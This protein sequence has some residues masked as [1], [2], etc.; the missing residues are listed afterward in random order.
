MSFADPRTSIAAAGL[1]A[2]AVGLLG[3][4]GGLLWLIGGIWTA[5]AMAAAPVGAAWGLACLAAGLRWGSLD[6]GDLQVATRL[7][8][9]TVAAGGLATRAGMVLA[10]AGALIGEARVDGLRARTFG[11]RAAAMIALTALV[12]LF[13][14]EGP[15]RSGVVAFGWW[16]LAGVVVTALVVALTP[17][18][19]RLPAL[20][21][22]GLVGAGMVLAGA[23]G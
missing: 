15:A 5:R 9:P 6:V 17:I 13:C 23:A 20:V 11:E 4:D 10:L 12:A 19:S 22:V 16:G 3:V 7:I 18:A 2:A 14:V 21:P 1:A 8:A